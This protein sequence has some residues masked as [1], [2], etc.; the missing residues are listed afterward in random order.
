[1]TLLVDKVAPGDVGLSW[2]DVAPSCG[3]RANRS[4]T[5]VGGFTD[6]SG[7]VLPSNFIDVGAGISPDTYYYLVSVE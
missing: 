3:Y 1:M 7:P 5:P 4:T 2:V 6:I